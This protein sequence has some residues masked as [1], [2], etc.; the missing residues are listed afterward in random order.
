VKSIAIALAAL[1]LGTGVA[2]AD[3]ADNQFL[4]TLT[5]NE[6][7]CTGVSFLNCGPK[8]EQS[9][10]DLGKDICDTMRSHNMNEATAVATL[11]RAVAMEGPKKMP[12]T[13]TKATVFVQAAEAAYCPDLRN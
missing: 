2:H 9:L 4:N 3:A 5:V 8:G 11:M 12:M 7:G 13:E 10:I 6:L 1:V